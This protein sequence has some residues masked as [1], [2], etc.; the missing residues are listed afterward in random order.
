MM[1]QR[2]AKKRRL[3][4]GF[5]CLGIF[6]LSALPAG[7]QSLCLATETVNKCLER[8]TADIGGEAQAGAAAKAQTDVKKKTETGLQDINGLTSS[9]KDFLPL[10]QLSGVL[11]AVQKDDTTGTVSVALN[12]PFLGSSG[13]L[14]EDPSFQLKAVIET[15]PKLFDELLK[16]LPADKRDAVEKSLLSG[17][18]DAED[19]TL[20]ASYNFTSQRLGRNFARHMRLYN[21]LFQQAVAGSTS[22]LAAA[23]AD[24]LRKLIRALGDDVSLDNTLWAVIPEAKRIAAQQILLESVHAHLALQTAFASAVKSAGLD[25]FGQLI[26]NQPQLFIEVS[27]AFRDDLYGPDLLSGRITF[28]MG[29]ANNLNGFFN[30]FDARNCGEETVTCLKKYSSYVN[31]GNTTANVKAGSRLVMYAEF[32]QHEDYHYANPDVGLDVAFSKGTTFSVGLDYGR[33]LGVSDMGV[34]DGR[35]DASVLWEHRSDVPDETRFVTSITIT[36]KVGEISIP[37]GIVYANKPRYLTGVNQGLTANV[38]LKF[39]LF[40][41]LK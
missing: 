17:K 25:L 20:F 22:A 11:G 12:T 4:L 33:L 35:V 36:K 27:R 16:N 26:N 5:F 10:L 38:G 29:L 7:A 3:S 6:F 34:A 21:Q 14:T 13:K 31:D 2:F 15:T 40:P 30:L 8:L 41:G 18:T 19:A 37:F 28:E 1:K 39:N 32:I 9:V 24:V 23:E